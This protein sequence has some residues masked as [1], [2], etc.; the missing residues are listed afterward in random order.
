MSTGDLEDLGG[1]MYGTWRNVCGALTVRQVT[2][3]IRTKE[4][5]NYLYELCILNNQFSDVYIY[6]PRLQFN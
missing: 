4:M 3:V 6:M 1:V 5:Q 2:T